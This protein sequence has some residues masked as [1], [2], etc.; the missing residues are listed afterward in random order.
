MNRVTVSIETDSG[1]RPSE[2]VADLRSAAE[3]LYYPMTV[4][5][6]WDYRLDIHLCPQEERRMPCPHRLPCGH[7]GRVDYRATMER[8][9]QA[10]L[11]V[12]FPHADI[13][14]FLS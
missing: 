11:E 7:R 9:R 4:V 2:I 14:L 12:F 8:E 3:T 6:F 10:N 5:G 1:I 13:A